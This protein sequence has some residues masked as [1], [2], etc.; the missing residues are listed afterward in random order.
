[1]RCRGIRP[2][3]AQGAEPGFALGNRRKRVQQVAGGSRQPVK[4][5]HHEHVAR[6]KRLDHPVKLRPVGL[7]SAHMHIAEH[8]P[9]SIASL[10]R[11]RFRFC[12]PA[13]LA[14]SRIS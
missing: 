8:P 3:I 9:W 4:P 5:C 10:G 12:R 7:G 14:H 1:V 11:Q 6:L 13:T 2:R